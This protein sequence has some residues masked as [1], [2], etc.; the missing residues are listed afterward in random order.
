MIDIKPGMPVPLI[1]PAMVNAGDNAVVEVRKD[2]N[3][4]SIIVIKDALHRNGYPVRLSPKIT[5][6]MAFAMLEAVGVPVKAELGKR[7]IAG[8]RG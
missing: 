1:G 6:A 4:G 7:L 2:L 8:S 3:G 5:V